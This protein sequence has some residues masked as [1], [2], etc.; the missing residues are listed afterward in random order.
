MSKE[1]YVS[2]IVPVYNEENSV[3]ELISQLNNVL[4]LSGKQY[5][6]IFIDDGSTDK[7]ADKIK[8]IKDENVK[9]IQFQRN[10]GK[11]VA[12]SCGFSN[13]LGDIIV[14]MDGDLQDNPKEI[15]RFIE[16]LKKYDMVSGWKFDRIDPLSKKIPSK[17][18]NY[19]TTILTG[20]KIHDFNC[21]YKAYRQCVIK[22]I[23]IYGELH[24]Y[25]PAIAYWKGYTVGE[26]KVDHRARI[27]GK[28]KYG[29]ERILKGFLDL[30]TI[31]FLMSYA[32]RPLHLFGSIGLI[33]AGFGFIINVYLFTLWTRGIKIGDRPLLM[34]GILFVI[35]GIQFISM[36]LIGELTTNRRHYDKYV[37]RN[38]N[39]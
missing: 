20:I 1:I 7:T 39:E 32:E 4:S 11:S 24:R 30:I 23:N 9:L 31:K 17:F 8:K 3:I 28:S 16:E 14:T 10:F 38:D 13:S 18:F 6:I 25:V 37:I 27:H 33:L 5:E 35:L 36:G 15:P 26:I 22:N 12:L 19:L 21:G 2:V 29:V 34:L